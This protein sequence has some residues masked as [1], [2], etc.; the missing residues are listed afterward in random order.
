M[1]MSRALPGEHLTPLES[2]LETMSSTLHSC[3]RE[4]MKLRGRERAH[5][6]T[7]ESTN[8]RVL[9]WSILEASLL[10]AVGVWQL[11]SL[12]ASLSS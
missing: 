8:T 9:W 10:C 11:R 3:E 1:R 6:D 5:R 12:K 4:Q 7:V 2:A